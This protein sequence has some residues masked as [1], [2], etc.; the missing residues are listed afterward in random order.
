MCVENFP[1]SFAPFF[2][3]IFNFVQLRGN[4]LESK[5]LKSFSKFI[6]IENSRTRIRIV[7]FIERKFKVSVN[8]QALRNRNIACVLRYFLYEKWFC[9]QKSNFLLYFN[10]WY[11]NIRYK[12]NGQ[13][14]SFT[15]DGYIRFERPFR[16]S[17]VAFGQYLIVKLE[18]D[19]LLRLVSLSATK[20]RTHSFT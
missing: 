19:K 11:R 1:F 9:T 15:L 16:P 4:E 8:C 7:K 20:V 2:I 14:D 18:Q 12:F 5:M 10:K 13:L 6:H 3:S 17:N